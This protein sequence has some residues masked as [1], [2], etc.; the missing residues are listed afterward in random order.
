MHYSRLNTPIDLHAQKRGDRNTGFPSATIL[1]VGQN[2][3]GW[4]KLGAKSGQIYLSYF[5]Y[6][7]RLIFIYHMTLAYFERC[8]KDQLKAR[9]AELETNFIEKRLEVCLIT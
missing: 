5:R 4:L 9:S 3:R 6:K 7:K 8:P 2:C 1:E